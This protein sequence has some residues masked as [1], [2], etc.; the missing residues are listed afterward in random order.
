[1]KKMNNVRYSDSDLQEFKKI[2]LAK[3]EIAKEDLELQRS[4]FRNVSGHG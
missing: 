2:I 1:M 3:M 4:A